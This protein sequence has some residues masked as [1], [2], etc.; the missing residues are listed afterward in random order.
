M[1]NRSLVR[2]IKNILAKIF[3]K[4]PDKGTLKTRS[5]FQSH[6]FPSLVP[7]F[8]VISAGIA[9]GLACPPWSGNSLIFIC[10][11]GSLK[12]ETSLRAI[13]SIEQIILTASVYPARFFLLKKIIKKLKASTESFCNLVGTQT[14]KLLYMCPSLT[15]IFLQST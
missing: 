11:N 1:Q 14:I 10:Q 8:H 13:V 5:R 6:F 15:L 3:V 4:V 7:S 2:C 9:R 12:L